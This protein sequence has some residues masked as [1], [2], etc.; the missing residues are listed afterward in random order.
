MSER[1]IADFPARL[2]LDDEGGLRSGRVVMS[3]RRLVFVWDLDQRTAGRGAVFDVSDRSPMDIGEVDGTVL[4]VGFDDGDR[5]TVAAV[6]ADDAVVDRFRELLFKML[7]NDHTVAVAVGDGAPHERR[8]RVS[9]AGVRFGGEGGVAVRTTDILGVAESGDEKAAT[10]DLVCRAGDGRRTVR[11]TFRDRSTYNVFG[12]F[13]SAYVDVTGAGAGTEAATADDRIRV[14]FVDDEPGLAS[15]IADNVV[16]E[17][18]RIEGVAETDPEAGVRRVRGDPSIRCVVSDYRMPGMDGLELLRAVRRDRPGL[19]FVLFTGRGSEAVASEAM[20]AG[21]TDYLPKEVRAETWAE[22]ARRVER[23][24]D[25]L[26]AKGTGT[27][28]VSRSPSGATRS[29]SE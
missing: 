22:L 3:T 5:R 11:V 25:T 2:W 15:M 1:A 4:T 23:A 17:S 12:R 28:A 26:E 20:A 19:P 24:V 18:D 10:A 16:R 14:L 29:P 21:V 7:L 6:V 8:I 13:L 9:S 27:G